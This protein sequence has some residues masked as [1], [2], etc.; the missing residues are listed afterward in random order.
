MKKLL[1]FYFHTNDI[2][3]LAH[4]NNDEMFTQ[5]DPEFLGRVMVQPRVCLSET[6]YAPPD[7]PSQLQ[8]CDLHRGAEEAGQILAAFELIEV[9][10]WHETLAWAEV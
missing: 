8:W 7:W 1:N 3:V 10:D 5:G 4:S 2:P 9:R 6:P